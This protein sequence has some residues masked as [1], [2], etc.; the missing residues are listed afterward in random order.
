MHRQTPK[1]TTTTRWRAVPQPKRR[2]SRQSAHNNESRNR[3]PLYFVSSL[4]HVQHRSSLF[5]TFNIDCLLFNQPS[6]TICLDHKTRLSASRRRPNRFRS[7]PVNRKF[8]CARAR[9]P[10]A[11]HYLQSSNQSTILFYFYCIYCFLFR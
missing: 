1:S 9:A 5:K 4:L 11:R 8:Y 6:H 10:L 3:S 2:L 7:C